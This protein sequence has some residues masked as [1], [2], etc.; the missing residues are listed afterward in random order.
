LSYKS[1]PFGISEHSLFL[2]LIVKQDIEL[3]N[4]SPFIVL[5]DFGEHLGLLLFGTCD[6]EDVSAPGNSGDMR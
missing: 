6:G 4:G 3:L 2:L 1:L 5:I